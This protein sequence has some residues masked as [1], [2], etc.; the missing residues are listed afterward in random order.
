MGTTDLVTLIILVLTVVFGVFGIMKIEEM[1]FHRI[2]SIL[3]ILCCAIAFNNQLAVRHEYEAKK[4]DLNIEAMQLKFDNKILEN[5]LI[6][7]KK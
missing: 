7:C 5:R 4:S 2:L 6:G 1:T 3:S